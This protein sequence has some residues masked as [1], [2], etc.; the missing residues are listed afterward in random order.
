MGVRIL[1]LLVLAAT[2][3]RAQSPVLIVPPR[4][5]AQPLS[6]NVL[7]EELG[8]DTLPSRIGQKTLDLLVHKASAT[9]EEPASVAENGIESWVGATVAYNFASSGDAAEKLS[10]AGQMVLNAWTPKALNGS[11]WLFSMPIVGNVATPTSGKQPAEQLKAKAD[12]LLTAASGIYAG[13]QPYVEWK[14]KSA[15]AARVYGG[16]VVRTNSL[17]DIDTDSSFFMTTTRF[18]LGGAVSIGEFTTGTG[19]ANIEFSYTRPK[20][21]DYRRAY[22]VDRKRLLSTDVMLILPIAESAGVLGQA[23]FNHTEHRTL[24][25]A[26]VALRPRQ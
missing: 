8:A 10:V 13:I 11:T 6:R 25:R 16:A 22:G 17:K 3:L 1:V 5:H 23:V 20:E 15:Y 24:W 21:G 7:R 14:G 9:T 19:V 4:A 18:S 2:S 26:G 12:E